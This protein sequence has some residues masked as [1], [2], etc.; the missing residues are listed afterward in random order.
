V[1]AWNTSIQGNH[2]AKRQM[3]LGLRWLL[4]Q[5]SARKPWGWRLF[6]PARGAAGGL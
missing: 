3:L 4:A 5:R 6:P 1:V 2:T